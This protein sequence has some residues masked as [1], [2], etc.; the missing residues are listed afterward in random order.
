VR[1]FNVNAA[2]D[3]HN[4]EVPPRPELE[5]TMHRFNRQYERDKRPLWGQ[6]CQSA[7]TLPARPL[8]L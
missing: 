6:E 5:M 1:L 8:R 3:E 7:N 4:V 2:N